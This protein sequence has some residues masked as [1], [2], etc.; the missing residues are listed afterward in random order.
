MIS[1]W[2][3]PFGLHGLYKNNSVIQGLKRTIVVFS[4]Q[5]VSTC[6]AEL[7]IPIFQAEISNAISGLKR[8]NCAQHAHQSN[9]FAKFNLNWKSDNVNTKNFPSFLIAQNCQQKLTIIICHV[10][11]IYRSLT[12]LTLRILPSL[13]FCEFANRQTI[14]NES[15]LQLAKW[16]RHGQHI[17]CGKNNW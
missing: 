11:T 13:V 7:F 6:V 5:R 17:F 12:M 10:K 4:R 16:Q 1:N 14:E 8:Q 2:K 3:K 9:V 15:S